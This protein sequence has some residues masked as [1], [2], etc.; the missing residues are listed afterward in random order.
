MWL[1]WTDETR[2]INAANN[3]LR[4]RNTRSL[5]APAASSDPAH[6]PL[7]IPQHRVEGLAPSNHFRVL[8]LV[9]AV[10][11]VQPWLL[12]LPIVFVMD[13]LVGHRIKVGLAPQSRNELRGAAFLAILA[14]Y[15]VGVPVFLLLKKTMPTREAKQLGNGSPL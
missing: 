7:V 15:A 8:W 11:G 9:L 12:S 10:S 3:L 5:V 1:G 2:F 6:P 14:G 4:S 13:L